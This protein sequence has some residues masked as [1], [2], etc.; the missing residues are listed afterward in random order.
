MS[1]VAAARI[2]VCDDTGVAHLASNY[3]TPSVVL[4]GPVS[5]TV[6]GPPLHPRHRVIFHGDGT[7]NPHGTE[8]DAAL[9]RITVREVLDGVHQV[10]QA[11]EN[12]PQ[13]VASGQGR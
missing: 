7:G 4:F 12:Q 13:P 8:P 10:L 6:W 11:V 3:R 5:P 9:L 1:L 2:V